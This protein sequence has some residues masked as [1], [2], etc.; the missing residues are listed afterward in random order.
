MNLR[1]HL[2]DKIGDLGFS[3][4]GGIIVSIVCPLMFIVGNFCL[5]IGLNFTSFIQGEIRSTFKHIISE[6]VFQTIIISDSTKFELNGAH[7]FTWWKLPKLA[8][9]FMVYLLPT[10]A[11][12]SIIS[13]G[14]TNLTLCRPMK[15]EFLLNNNSVPANN[16]YFNKLYH[17]RQAYGNQS[18]ERGECYGKGQLV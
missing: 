11:L 16:L 4:I 18:V 15:A 12:L 7:R 3:L 2:T 14:R 1:T 5:A 13:F 8:L 6:L 9:S 10:V 17:Q